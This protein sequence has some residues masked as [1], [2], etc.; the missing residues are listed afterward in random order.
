MEIKRVKNSEGCYD[1][2]LIDGSRKLDILFAGNLDLYMTLGSGKMI[3]DNTNVFINFD[4]TKENYEIYSLFDAMYNEIVEGKVF[5]RD[6]A[7]EFIED[8]T[9]YK[10]DEF[11]Y[12]D[13]YAYKE[14]VDEK[15]TIRWISD[16]GP[17]DV[18][19][20]VHIFRL[21]DDVIRLTFY[22]NDK[23]MDF[24]FKSCSKIVVRFRNSGSYYN[25]FNCV[26]MRMYQ[27]LQDIDPMYHQI[28]MEELEYVKKMKK[29]N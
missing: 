22:R 21:N 10:L 26:F 13:T 4:I 12:K 7:D 5:I 16:D 1:Y 19:D 8:I 2:Q 23:P 18:E 11:D 9:G 29:D 6:E 3:P 24:G 20:S 25:P 17:R 28:H 27:K 14:L 15:G